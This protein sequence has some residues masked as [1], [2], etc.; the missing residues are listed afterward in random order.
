MIGAVEWRKNLRQLGLP[1]KAAWNEVQ[2][3]YRR[4]V[5]ACHP[6]VNPCS[7]AAE[8]FR[9]ITAAYETLASLRRKR[10]AHSTEGLRQFDFDVRTCGLSEEELGARMRYSGSPQVRS[11][12]AYLLGRK[13]GEESRQLLLGAH[14]EPDQLVQMAVV[15]A[16]GR[17]GRPGDL[18]RFL[19][20]LWEAGSGRIIET[21]C[22]SWAGIWCRTLKSLFLSLKKRL[23]R[24][25][26]E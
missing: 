21:Y 17:I 5:L 2:D 13:G 22:L 25:C 3:G 1:R 6:D 18:W 10:K 9:R 4:M 19:P 26:E 15:E 12:A 23:A 16:L 7:A 11:A 14:R 24:E 20:F 8:R